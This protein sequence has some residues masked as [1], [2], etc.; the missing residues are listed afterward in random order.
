[1]KRSIWMAS[2]VILVLLLAG[3]A[4]VGGRMLSGQSQVSHGGSGSGSFMI[5]GPGGTRSFDIVPA[6]ELPSASPDVSGILV[7]SED[8]SLIVGTGEVR[9]IMNEG[10]EIGASHDG[11]EVDVVVTHSTVVY[12][13]TTEFEI[14][15]IEDDKIQETVKPGSLDEVEKNYFVRAWG[16]E[17]GDRLFADVLVYKKP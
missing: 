5:S 4:F 1:M 12:C 17:R 10:G 3:A 16:E 13:D 14:N 6:D 7:R 9:I 2:G 11:P 8:N 15:Q